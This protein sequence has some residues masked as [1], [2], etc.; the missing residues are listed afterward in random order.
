MTP[1]TVTEAWPWGDGRIAWM[2]DGR[3]FSGPSTTK[4]AAYLRE[5]GLVR[6]PKPE[7]L[8]LELA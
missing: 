3:M 2:A 6:S 5:R 4:W 1:V 8:R 7:P